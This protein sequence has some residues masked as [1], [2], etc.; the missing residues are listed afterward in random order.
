[1]IENGR[2]WVLV[3][4]DHPKDFPDEFVCRRQC[5]D[6]DRLLI[7]KELFAR[8]PTLESVRAQIPPGEFCIPRSP[9]DDPVIVETWL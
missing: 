7:E 3:I 9:E 4:Y 6:G 1:M 8:G 2:L 5:V